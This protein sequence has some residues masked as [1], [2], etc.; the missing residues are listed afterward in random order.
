MRFTSFFAG[1]KIDFHLYSRIKEL[2]GSGEKEIFPI[3]NYPLR[4]ID[5]GTGV[6]STFPRR[7]V[8]SE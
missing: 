8:K 3:L 7:K 5:R 2:K 6:L 1:W 4:R